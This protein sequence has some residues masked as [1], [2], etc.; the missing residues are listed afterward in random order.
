M[1][2]LL[3]ACGPGCASRCAEQRYD[4]LTPRRHLEPLARTCAARQNHESGGLE[5]AA[6]ALL[7]RARSADSPAIKQDY[8]ARCAGPH[9]LAA[10]WR[11]P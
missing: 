2:H 10:R 6:A 3:P 1:H 9:D 5:G 8:L 4:L 11:R 7:E